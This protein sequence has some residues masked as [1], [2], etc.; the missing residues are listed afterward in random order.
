MDR[1]RHEMTRGRPGAARRRLIEPEGCNPCRSGMRLRRRRTPSRSRDS[2]AACVTPEPPP[3]SSIALNSRRRRRQERRLMPNPASKRRASVR[4]DIPSSRPPLL[5]AAPGSAGSACRASQIV[6]GHRRAARAAHSG[7]EL[8]TPELIEDQ[9]GAHGPNSRPD[10]PV[11]RYRRPRRSE[12]AARIE[13]LANRGV[14][15]Q[16]GPGLVGDPAGCG[17]PP[18]ARIRPTAACRSAATPPASARSRRSG[19]SRPPSAPRKWYR[20]PGS[21]GGAHAPGS[22]DAPEWI[23]H[24]S[25]SASGGAASGGVAIVSQV[26]LG[27]RVSS[28][29]LHRLS[30]R[31]KTA[32]AER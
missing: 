27:L 17:T 5:R 9:A 1:C 18:P 22:G 6:V 20:P 7:R 15:R 21:N 25:S 11:P 3:S 10:R 31:R 2:I 19:R 16:A 4:A 30:G 28:D 23:A 26:M 13:T 29:T 32:S 14:L 8:G 24:G 12:P